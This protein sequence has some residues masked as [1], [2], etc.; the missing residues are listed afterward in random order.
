MHLVKRCVFT[1]SKT[2]GRA[3]IKWS[4]A[5]CVH[6]VRTNQSTKIYTHPYACALFMNETDCELHHV[7]VG[8]EFKEGHWKPK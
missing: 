6:R 3:F 5:Q 8:L 2:A 7:N 4:E 1:C